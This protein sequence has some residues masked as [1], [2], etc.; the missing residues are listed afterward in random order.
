MK[1]KILTCG[2]YSCE[3]LK[4]SRT[5]FHHWFQQEDII[6]NSKLFNYFYP[7]SY[8]TPP[9]DFFKVIFPLMVNFLILHAKASNIILESLFY[10]NGKI[11]KLM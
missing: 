8:K 11:L 5:I 7:I 4:Y 10:K 9:F 2:F 1:Y 6:P 3:G